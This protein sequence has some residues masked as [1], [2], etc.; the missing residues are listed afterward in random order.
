[1]RRITAAA[2]L[3]AAGVVLVAAGSFPVGLLLPLLA[4]G[5]WLAPRARLWFA[6]AAGIAGLLAIGFA[7]VTLVRGY[8]AGFPGAGALVTLVGAVATVSGLLL[9]AGR[10][11]GHTYRPGVAGL[12]VLALAAVTTPLVLTRESWVVRA[13]TAGPGA[14]RPVPAAAGAFAWTAEV[15]GVRDVVGAGAG[16]VLLVPDGVV[17]LD[18]AT[19]A[20]RWSYRRVGAETRW[21]R[22][23]VDG[24]LVAVGLRP[25]RVVFLNAMT[26]AV[27]RVT[28]VT[29][30]AAESPWL[31]D[32][33]L[34][35]QIGDGSL[36]GYYAAFTDGDDT[37]RWRPAP[38]CRLDPR[39]VASLG[40]QMLVAPVCD[41][42]GDGTADR[43]VLT[44]LDGHNGTTS[45]ELA[46]ALRPTAGQP[47]VDLGVDPS[48]ALVTV[49]N[50]ADPAHRAWLAAVDGGLRPIGTPV[51]RLLRS[52]LA[53]DPAG[54]VVDARTGAVRW[55][56]S[57]AVAA[58]GATGL[59]LSA[60][61]A[62][63]ADDGRSLAAAGYGAAA[64]TPLGRAELSRPRF[65]AAPGAVVAFDPGSPMVIGLR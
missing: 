44:R 62:C 11:D 47:V 50:A 38:G 12:V 43:A 56:P 9:G 25:A 8:E 16:P 33:S 58:C 6:G 63:L 36:V 7:L 27:A 10:V 34:V 40:A 17:A 4:G 51:A 61:V 59:Y 23:S 31:T 5:V 22:A 2:T 3:F 30:V 15:T 49:E 45:A 21:V 52:G 42:N 60:G 53:L 14:A 41:V 32:V 26:G 37:W 29:R 35:S 48:A 13:T 1:M 24:R 55:R 54:S 39:S 19:G 65:A 18:G 57:G 64:V 20:P 46:V 28:D